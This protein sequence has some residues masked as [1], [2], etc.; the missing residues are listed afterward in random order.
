MRSLGDV[1]WRREGRWRRRGDT[2]GQTL[3]P[4]RREPVARK[5]VGRRACACSRPGSQYLLGRSGL[6][7]DRAPPTPAAV[8][9]DQLM[10]GPCRFG[11]G[12][13]PGRCIARRPTGLGYGALYRGTRARCAPS[14][15]VAGLAPG[16]AAACRVA[17]EGGGRATA[18]E[19]RR[20]GGRIRWLQDLARAV[21]SRARAARM[22]HAPQYR[23][24]QVLAPP[25]LSSRALISAGMSSTRGLVQET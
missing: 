3:A 24:L 8:S 16:I 20:P 15:A 9:R 14:V 21:R 13:A 19:L 23:P 18:V 5:S 25:T 7:L 17:G 11:D 12:A 1:A 4:C 6:E 22:R 2:R 10:N